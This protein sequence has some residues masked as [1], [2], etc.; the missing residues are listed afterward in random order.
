MYKRRPS[1]QM[2]ALATKIEPNFHTGSFR[3]ENIYG[4]PFDISNPISGN[5]ALRT[6]ASKAFGSVAGTEKGDPNKAMEVVV[7]VVRGEGKAKGR[8]WPLYLA[9]GADSERDI[10][11]KVGK[12]VRHV[13]EWGGRN[14]GRQ[15]RWLSH[16]Q[17]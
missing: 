5:D 17:R 15:F 8:E 11:T 2:Q 6:K 9:L 7:D 10:R 13:D 16:K 4:Q 14:Q 12:L 1:N 3:T